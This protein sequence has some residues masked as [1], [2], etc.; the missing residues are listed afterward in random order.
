MSTESNTVGRSEVVDAA[1][2]TRLQGLLDRLA[3]RKRIGHVVMGAER[4]DGSWSWAGAAGVA[5]REGTP[6]RADTP[7]FIASVTKLYIAT[8]VLQLHEEGE[9]DLDGPITDYLSPDHTDRLH[10]ID[11]VD[12]SPAIT[13]RHLLSH[14][15][16]LPDYLEDRRRTSRRSIYGDI[17]EGADLAWDFDDVVRISRDDMSPHFPP[18]DLSTQRQRARYSDTGFQMLLAVIEAVAGEPFPVVFEERLFRPLDLRHTWFPGRSQPLDPTV[19]EPAALWSRGGPLSIPATL[20][21]FNDLM[22]TTDDTLRFLAGLQTGE[23]FEDSATA[24]LM[25]ERW[26][27]VHGPIRYGLGTMKYRIP[28]VY[29]PGRGP[30]HLIGHTGATGSW[31]FH[32]PELDLTLTGTVDEVNARSLP[33]RLLIRAVRAAAK[34]GSAPKDGT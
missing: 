4:G 24:A 5:D 21:S 26:N 28:A 11:G 27:R 1:A 18:Q 8:V 30:A 12:H 20:R 17:A 6:M 7:Y 22:S 31:L 10:V 25:H 13:I 23:V 9:I 34:V 14:T 16:G 15:S 29:A 19:G 32:C 33:F 2:A 3:S